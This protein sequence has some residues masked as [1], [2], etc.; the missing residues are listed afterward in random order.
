MS[1][2]EGLHADQP[3]RFG[4]RENE[5]VY[6]FSKLNQKSEKSPNLIGQVPL[7]VVVVVR[8]E[9]FYFSPEYGGDHNRKTRYR[10]FFFLHWYPPKKL[11]YGKP[12][13]GESTLT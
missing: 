1:S 4:N 6:L 7:V 3:H 2:F 11:K 12:R 13:L 5:Q 9:T 10:V 8:G